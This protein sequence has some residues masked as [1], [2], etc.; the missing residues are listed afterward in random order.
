MNPANVYIPDIKFGGMIKSFNTLEEIIKRVHARDAP[1]IAIKYHAT[2]CKPCK[3]SA[4]W[5]ESLVNKFPE[6]EFASVDIDDVEAV[7]DVYSVKTIP[8]IHVW[9]RG[10]RAGVFTNREEFSGVEPL[11]VHLRDHNPMIANANQCSLETVDTT[12]ETTPLA[13]I[14]IAELG[15]QDNTVAA[16]VDA[17][18]PATIPVTLSKSEKRKCD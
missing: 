16:V 18:V 6:M 11:L 17:N 2:W 14:S 8:T 9:Y 15:N 13:T 3:D 12:V 1:A 5:F 4:K 10:G 7:L